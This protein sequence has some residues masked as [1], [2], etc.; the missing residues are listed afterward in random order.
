MK[1]TLILLILIINLSFAENSFISMCKNPT[2]SQI[3]TLKAM[4]KIVNNDKLNK[5]KIEFHN[6]KICEILDKEF[7]V[8]PYLQ[9]SNISDISL[10]KYFPKT[11]TLD[12]W[13]NKITDITPLKYLTNLTKLNL[14]SND[15][16]KGVESL[17]NL[18]LKELRIVFENDSVDLTPIGKIETLV[19]LY[20][21]NGKNSQILNNLK[22]IK[23]LSLSSVDIKSLCDLTDLQ[24]LENLSLFNNNLKSLE[25]ID[26]FK[27]LKELE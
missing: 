7:V 23:N 16:S 1:K 5:P 10:L 20:I 17:E 22:N 2:P 11:S 12:L 3:I 27:N 6:P 18:P 4:L 21:F 26:Q 14:G 19:N 25:C 13:N 24:S 9:D 15:V 8:I